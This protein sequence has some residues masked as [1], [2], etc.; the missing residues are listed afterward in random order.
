MKLLAISHDIEPLETPQSIQIGR[1][2]AHLDDWDILLVSGS[3]SDKEPDAGSIPKLKGHLRWPSPS[4]PE[5]VMQRLARLTLP[6]YGKCP[7]GLRHWRTAVLPRLHAWLDETNH[8]P[9]VMISFGEPMSD[10]LLALEIKRLRGLPW[11]AHFS[12]PW[13][14]NPFRRGGPLTGMLNRRLERRVI[15]GADIVVFTSRETADLVGRRYAPQQTSKFRI[16][17]HG[18]DA[19]LYPARTGLTGRV[20][21]R[22]V[23]SFYGERTPFPLIEALQLLLRQ[24]PA[25]SEQLRLE[26]V[27]AMPKRMALKL[28]S[29]GLPNDLLTIRAPIG[30]RD[31]IALISATDLLVLVDAPAQQSV[32][33]ASKLIDYVGAGRPILAITPAGAAR[34]VVEPLGGWTASPENPEAI[35]AALKSAVDFCLRIRDAKTFVWGADEVRGRYAAEVVSAQLKSYLLETHRSASATRR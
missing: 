14:D 24:D 9:D 35:A 16:L 12:D 26:L 21:I 11:L 20:T 30:Y 1:L 33:L 22:H 31:S 32:F 7:D 18:F 6:V 3:K 15:E 34:S 19:S 10:H 29:A 23:G 25:I 8:K 2:L 4:G 17:P 27:G 5:T 28:R 13:A